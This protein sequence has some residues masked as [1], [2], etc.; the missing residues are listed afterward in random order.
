M[1]VPPVSEA[2]VALPRATDRASAVDIVPSHG[3]ARPRLDVRS[4]FEQ[5][6][7]FVWRAVR[8][9]GVAE[10][11][12]DDT[13]QEVFVVVHRKL[14]EF[15]SRSKLTTWLYGICFRVASDHLRKVRLHR[16]EITESVPDAPD[17]S[18]TPEERLEGREARARLDEVLASLDTDKRAVFVM[19]EIDELPVETIAEIVG[20]PV[21]TVY[22]RLRAA[23]EEFDRAVARLRARL[24]HR[25][26]NGGAA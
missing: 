16:E 8:R 14:P 20:V 6:F 17:P 10:S 5:H 15:E 19:Y 13:V 26:R 24:A 21:G 2:A 4:V 1:V 7:D 25:A 9:L 18:D 3:H 23:R 11:D 12:V 22:S